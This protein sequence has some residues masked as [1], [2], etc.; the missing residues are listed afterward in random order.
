[1]IDYGLLNFITYHVHER[2]Q[3]MEQREF[4]MEEMILGVF[5]V[6]VRAV[7]CHGPAADVH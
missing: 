5:F 7:I 4:S 6:A 2:F 3:Y 1:M